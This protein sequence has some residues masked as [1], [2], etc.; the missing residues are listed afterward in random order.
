MCRSQVY[1]MIPLSSSIQI[2]NTYQEPIQ[3]TTPEP[4]VPQS[5]TQEE[6]YGTEDIRVITH[7]KAC[8]A[9]ASISG[10]GIRGV[11]PATIM[12][13]IEKRTGK[14]MHQLFNVFSGVS[15]GSLVAAAANRPVDPLSGERIVEMFEKEASTI[16]PYVS[17]YNPVNWWNSLWYPKYTFDGMHEVLKRY[18]GDMTLPDALNPLVIPTA[19]MPQQKSWWFTSSK[20]FRREQQQIESKGAP[21]QTYLNNDLIKKI[22]I[23]DIL[24]ASA[25][26]PT[27]FP[28]KKMNIADGEHHFM[29]GGTIANNPVVIG[30]CYSR[31]LYGSQSDDIVAC[32]GTGAPSDNQLNS[33]N[34]SG[35]VYWGKNYATASLNL[36]AD[37]ASLEMEVSM[38]HH[39]RE[40]YVCQPAIDESIYVL[41]SSDPAIIKQLV[42]SAE[43]FIDENEEMI[44]ELCI[45]LEKNSMPEGR[46]ELNETY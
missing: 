2:Q 14:P 10:G 40:L 7:H 31:W 34:N 26:A 6:C 32:F 15:S 29:D 39:P 25:A 22:P 33:E 35:L 38:E 46:A 3:M 8:S 12:K 27:F 41:D 11:I 43:R 37:E 20:I 13:N 5:T 42:E 45:K 9:L 21:M 23:V 4:T 44:A 18:C 24:E 28:Y 19:E 1:L 16:F 17:P 36:V 30:R